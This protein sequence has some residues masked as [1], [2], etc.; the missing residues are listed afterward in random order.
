M[1]EEDGS[2]GTMMSNTQPL[3]DHWGVELATSL[4]MLILDRGALSMTVKPSCGGSPYFVNFILK[5][6]S[7][8]SFHVTGRPD[9]SVND[10]PIHYVLRYTARAVGETQSSPDLQNDP[11]DSK[12][13]AL[14]Q[15]GMY[16]VDQLSSLVQSMAAVVP[17]QVAIASINSETAHSSNSVSFKFID[18][19]VYP[20]GLTNPKNICQN[21][22]WMSSNCELPDEL[23]TLPMYDIHVHRCLNALLMGYIRVH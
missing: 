13:R 10:K 2:L 14:S 11:N 7:G 3:N 8:N 20:L 18:Q 5:T 1:G 6:P 21:I 16:A 15:A 9:F 4:L 19:N 23:N 12:R 17:A 22:L